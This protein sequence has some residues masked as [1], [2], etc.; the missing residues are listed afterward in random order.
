MEIQAFGIGSVGSNA[1]LPISLF[2]FMEFLENAT[3][4]KSEPTLPNLLIF[5]RIIKR[6]EKK[7]KGYRDSILHTQSTSRQ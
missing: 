5:H 6:F 3:S 4:G 7:L 2:S 1:N